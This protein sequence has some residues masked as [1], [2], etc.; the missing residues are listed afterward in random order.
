[1]SLT[2]QQERIATFRPEVAATLDRHYE[3]IAEDK[4][5]IGPLDPDFDAYQD[6]ENKDKLRILT[7]RENGKLI[8]YYIA[9]LGK[10]L[11]YKTIIG[12]A[13]DIHYIAPEHRKGTVG[14]RLLVEAEKMIRA[15]RATLTMAKTKVA[16]DH[17]LIFER[18]GYRPFERVFVK[19]L[20]GE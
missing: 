16:H 9:I 11:H 7:A 15:A 13:E 4:S 2:F 6:L 12:A 14:I 1:M 20:K 5:I 10:S 3:E 18:L 8:G 19:V 17:G